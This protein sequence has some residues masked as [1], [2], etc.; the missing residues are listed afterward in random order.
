MAL[1]RRRVPVHHRGRHDPRRH[2]AGAYAVTRT[3]RP[4]P[5][6]LGQSRACQGD[7]RR[8]ALSFALLAP[9]PHNRQPWMVD[10]SRPD[11]VVLHVDTSR[12]LPETDPFNRQITI[13]LGCFL[14]VMRMAAAQQGYRVDIG[15][16]PRGRERHR[17]GRAPVARGRLRGGQRC[18]P[19][20]L[21]RPCAGKALPEGALRSRQAPWHPGV[22]VA[23][24]RRRTACL[25]ASAAR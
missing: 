13:G 4:R 9:N 15:A 3:P 12:L 19:D 10:L 6:A 24:R 22:I 20:P 21:L 2:G 17:A 11:E 14:E 5:G 1:S 23:T 8:K 7:P 25:V 16:L 18:R